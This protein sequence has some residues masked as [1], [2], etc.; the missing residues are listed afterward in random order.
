M[1]E[2]KGEGDRVGSAVGEKVGEGEGFGVV[3]VTNTKMVEV[4]VTTVPF[5][6]WI[7]TLSL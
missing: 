5:A 6:P 4:F 3:G 1:Y 2:G 7:L